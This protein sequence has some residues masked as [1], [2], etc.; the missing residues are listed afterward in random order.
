[1]SFT[2]IVITGAS[3]GIGEAL[4][5]AYAAPGVALALNGRDGERLRTVAE[6]CRAK[7]AAVDAR[8]IDVTDRAALA[9]WLAAFDDAHPVDL[10]IANA[11]ISIDKDNSSLDDFSVIRRTITVNLDGV[12]NTVEPLVG[13]MMARKRGQI[14]VVSSLAGFIGLPY[15]ASY[16]A[17]KA[18]VRVWGESIRYPLRKSGVGVSVICPGFVIT[19]MT[20]QAPFPM[21]FLMT[22][23]RAATIIRRGLARNKARIAFPIGTKAAVW[24]GGV[25]PGNWTARLLGA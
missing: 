11:G 22:A 5:C 19:R 13:R 1:M 9:Q 7:G 4:A 10:L 21:P 14:A 2:S 16:N 23:E 24:L 3:S 20:A 18:A 25:L 6:A 17:S 8:Q 15:S 12:L